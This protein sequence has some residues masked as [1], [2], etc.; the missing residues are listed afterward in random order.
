MPEI[1]DVLTSLI[2]KQGGNKSQIARKLGVIGDKKMTSQQIGHYASGKYKPKGDFYKKWKEVFGDDLER[3]VEGNVS[4]E[5]ASGII[6]IH[7]EVWHELQENN[8]TYKEFLNAYKESF[9]ELIK[10]VNT[11]MDNLSKPVNRKN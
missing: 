9:N 5:N 8:K 4:K 11:T 2:E 10:T 3:L 7:R 6:P 1:A